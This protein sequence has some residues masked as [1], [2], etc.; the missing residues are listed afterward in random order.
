MRL[1]GGIRWRSYLRASQLSLF[2]KGQ[3][4]M[5]TAYAHLAWF[6]VG[7]TMA[8]AR[9]AW[10]PGAAQVVG[11][12]RCVR[13]AAC[14]VGSPVSTHRCQGVRSG[15]QV[16]IEVQACSL[17][18]AGSD[19]GVIRGLASAD[20]TAVNRSRV[21]VSQSSDVTFHRRCRMATRSIRYFEQRRQTVS[22]RFSRWTSS[23][24]STN[25]IPYRPCFRRQHNISI[26][27]S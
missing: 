4:T 21:R 12:G 14:S 13:A 1:V 10:A 19:A 11:T 3:I 16:H 6:A 18:L 17:E 25:S 7:L 15:S 20:A 9:A 26:L 27:S 22:K 8:A 23:G 2:F 5:H 24:Y